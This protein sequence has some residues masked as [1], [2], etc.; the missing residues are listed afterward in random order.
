MFSE[1]PSYLTKFEIN[2]ETGECKEKRISGKILM[3]FRTMKTYK[4][5]I[6]D[7][8]KSFYSKIILIYIKLFC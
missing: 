2:L 8:K 4:L 7:L 3:I 6:K 1:E 5:N